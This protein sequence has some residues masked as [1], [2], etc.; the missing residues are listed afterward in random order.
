MGWFLCWWATAGCVL[1]VG[2][3]V[4]SPGALYYMHSKYSVVLWE[5]LTCCFEGQFHMC[6]KKYRDG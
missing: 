6:F 4:I 5:H 2:D 1:V 3:S